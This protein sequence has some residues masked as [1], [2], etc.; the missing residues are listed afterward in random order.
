MF[1]LCAFLLNTSG[2]KAATFTFMLPTH[3]SGPVHYQKQ[4]SA[5]E[6]EEFAEEFVDKLL[7]PS[8]PWLRTC[9]LAGFANPELTKELGRVFGLSTDNFNSSL[10]RDFKDALE[11]MDRVK[12]VGK[13]KP[14]FL[15]D[16]PTKEQARIF[17]ALDFGALMRKAME[18]A[19][20]EFTAKRGRKPKAGRR[21]YTKIA[22]WG[23]RLYPVCL[24]VLTELRSGTHRSVRELLELWKQDFPEACTLLLHH[25]DRFESALK[26]K[27][28][29]KRAMGIE[30]RARLLADATAGADYGLKFRT[31]IERAREGRRLTARVRT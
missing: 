20:H 17:R 14:E 18:G 19:T 31:S 3:S 28:L 15:K 23:D 13:V 26:D 25:L 24:K 4:L 9:I 27:R 7:D 2:R 10:T 5:T 16:P 30:S 21:E 29:L 8:M 11:K 22:M 6:C 1:A 12:L